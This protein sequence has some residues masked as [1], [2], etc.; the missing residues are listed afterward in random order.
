MAQTGR[1][2]AV[3]R[4]DFYVLP[5]ATPNGRLLFACHLVEKA[6][7]LGHPVYLH[8]ASASMARHLDGLLWTYRQDTFLPH[9]LVEDVLP[10]IP[11]ILIGDDRGPEVVGIPIESLLA[12][13]H[14]LLRPTTNLPPW[15]GPPAVGAV[16]INLAAMVPSFFQHFA[17]VAELVDQE[18]EVLKAGR[19]RFTYY[20]DQGIVPE[21]H[22]L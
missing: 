1:E 9:A 4:V 8:T 7:T 12:S 17:R 15:E 20:R 21:N 2:N 11:S 3:P 13:M 14:T 5:D 6:Y 22:K 19:A 18:P 16:L 10:P